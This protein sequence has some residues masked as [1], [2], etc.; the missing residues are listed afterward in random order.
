MK[1]RQFLSNLLSAF[2]NPIHFLCELMK[3]F[4]IFYVSAYCCF[5][6]FVV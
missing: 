6:G 4:R 5:S 2:L 3:I 1:N